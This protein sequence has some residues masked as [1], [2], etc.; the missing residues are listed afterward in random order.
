MG[1][2]SIA[3]TID[4]KIIHCSYFREIELGE[5]SSPVDLAITVKH[6]YIDSLNISNEIILEQFIIPKEYLGTKGLLGASDVEQT[7][8]FHVLNL[9]YLKNIFI[10][11]REVRDSSS[12]LT[13]VGVLD[14][15]D[16]L[17]DTPLPNNPERYAEHDENISEVVPNKN[18]SIHNTDT[19]ILYSMK[20]SDLQVVQSS[21]R[22][23]LDEE[24]G[25]QFFVEQDY[26][27][28]DSK[29]YIENSIT[30]LIPNPQFVGTSNIP[31]QWEIEAPSIILN[32]HIETGEI[33]GTN[34]WQI[35]ASNPNIFSAFNSISLKTTDRYT[36]YSGLNYLT[37]SSYYRFK[38]DGVMP[39]NN[40]TVKVNFYANDDFIRSEQIDVTLSNEMSVWNLLVASFQGS[41]LPIT[42]NKY[43]IELDITE[44]NNTSL[45]TVE[46][47]LP[48]LEASPCSTTRTLDSRIQDKYVS[49]VFVLDLPF[50]IVVNTHHIT[51]QGTRGLCSSTTNQKNGFEFLA[52]N[53]R[54]RFKWYDLS[55]SVQLN[56][57]SAEI[58]ALQLNDVVNYG[59]LVTS[60]LIN[61]YINGILLS[62]HTNSITIL[63][64]Q[65]Y[66][67]GSLEKSNTTINSE[68]LDFKVLRNYV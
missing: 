45:F 51:G 56:I 24:N 38:C 63:Q 13:R 49:P 12:I 2:S 37:F 32:S 35:K 4:D 3:A 50:Y 10:E 53:D 46:F 34:I 43:S 67:V 19:G 26:N 22:I 48:Q 6:Q 44:I 1:T 58:T 11:C 57:A 25:E 27:Q 14:G 47:Y 36:L 60:S 52:S 21:R 68:L 16:E 18:I 8:E 5:S 54:L 40:F 41:Q 15:N 65:S 42:A 33:D 66:S 31:D 7:L 17:T 28:N 30:N 20:D 62:S 23:Y 64:N 9:R 39:F 29:V 55:G 59:V 61:F